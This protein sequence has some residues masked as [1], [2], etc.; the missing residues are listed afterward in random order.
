MF[1]MIK[2]FNV[3]N[4]DSARLIKTLEYGIFFCDELL[5][6]DVGLCDE[7]LSYELG[8]LELRVVA[9]CRNALPTHDQVLGDFPRADLIPP[10]VPVRG[11]LLNLACTQN[12]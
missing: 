2:H 1:A 7:G 10:P 3:P 11:D 5:L 6:R 8:V 9:R 4:L 12:V